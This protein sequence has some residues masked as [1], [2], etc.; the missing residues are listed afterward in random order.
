MLPVLL[1]SVG[2]GPSEDE[3]TP[4]APPP[5][6][7]DP[8][9]GL[10]PFERL[11]PDR[12]GEIVEVAWASEAT[13]PGAALQQLLEGQ[14]VDT[15]GLI[16]H[17]IR[18]WRIRYLTQDRGELVEATGLVAFPDDLAP[19]EAAPVV[20]W[21]HPTTGFD[22]A[23][24][25]SGPDVAN[26][27]GNVLLAAAGFVVVAPDY[28]GMA[29]WGAPS[30][31][32]HPYL[33]PEPTAIAT[34]DALRALWRMQDGEG[35]VV[36]PPGDGRTVLWG[37]SQGGNAALWADRFAPAY[38][39]E[40]HVTAVV[41]AVPPTDLVGLAA[42]AASSPIDATVGLLG[43]LPT[44][45][46]WYRSDAPLEEVLTDQDPLWLASSVGELLDAFCDP[47][48]VLPITGDEGVEDLY[49]TAWIDAAR[50]GQV[51][52]LEPWGCFLHQGTLTNSPLPRTS[53]APVLMVVGELDTL[54]VGS[55]ERDHVPALCAD[56]YPIS[57]LECE[58]ATHVDAAA[59]SLP[60][61]LAWVRDRLDGV[62]IIGA[63]EVGPPEPCA[64]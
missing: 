17:G 2:C 59:A 28:L 16:E 63:C 21:P 57:Y 47:D 42:A 61:Q 38:L 19:G 53:D 22:D 55:V 15:G 41:A 56:G 4:P 44:H 24:A 31:R 1:W 29:G 54:V 36:V 23:C 27:L 51:E 33:V 25:P 5:V 45:R 3:P 52:E 20:V 6:M 12:M 40:L 37:A 34:L 46:D 26:L 60:L 32:E 43:V 35:G 10:P 13:L 48:A 58:G 62:P 39:P 14:G 18:T 11:P 7:P 8:G 49:T 64:W 9:C 30:D 50:A